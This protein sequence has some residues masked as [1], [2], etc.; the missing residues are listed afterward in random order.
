MTGEER[1]ERLEGAEDA[2]DEQPSRGTA[3]DVFASEADDDDGK[4][5]EATAAEE[6]PGQGATD[7]DESE[8]ASQESKPAAEA[9]GEGE[10]EEEDSD[11]VIRYVGADEKSGAKGYP[12]KVHKD[13]VDKFDLYESKQRESLEYHRSQ[14]SRFAT[15][16]DKVKKGRQSSPAQDKEAEAR[17]D[18]QDEP[19]AIDRAKIRKEM[20]EHARKGDLDTMVDAYKPIM[21][22]ELGRQITELEQRSLERE[23]KLI[24]SFEGFVNRFMPIL[25]KE[26]PAIWHEQE[27]QFLKDQGF[28][29]PAEDGSAASFFTDDEV[30]DI[31]KAAAAEFHEQ[32]EGK[33]ESEK[34]L[35]TQNLFLKHA[36]RAYTKLAP[37]R[38]APKT[39]EPQ[40]KGDQP[41]PRRKAPRRQGDAPSSTHAPTPEGA[42]SGSRGASLNDVFAHQP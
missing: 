42:A 14:A 26:E 2:A 21:E 39:E 3:N 40:G 31:A 23:A 38:L 34:E 4:G 27:V 11:F 29:V 30:R 36:N 15:E 25:Q 12:V 13:D 41:P 5:S 28:A 9:K 1:E 8:Q 24:D 35:L 22:A 20:A 10:S 6:Q 7:E 19:P 17:P 32:S 37:E 16:A 33:S 18:K